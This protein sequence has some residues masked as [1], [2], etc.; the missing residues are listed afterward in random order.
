MAVLGYL[1]ATVWRCNE[2]IRREVALK[3]GRSRRLC[4]VLGIGAIAHVAAALL[5]Y[6][7][8]LW[9]HLALMP[10]GGHNVRPKS[11]P[12]IPVDCL[13]HASHGHPLLHCHAPG[14]MRRTEQGPCILLPNRALLWSRMPPAACMVRGMLVHSVHGE[15]LERAGMGLGEPDLVRAG[16]ETQHFNL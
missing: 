15:E 12:G 2:V 8:D 5:L 4:W 11:L 13:L 16:G 9:K 6:Q 3:E 10:A 1:T 14:C 7:Q